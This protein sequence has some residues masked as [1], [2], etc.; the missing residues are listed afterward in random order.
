MQLKVLSLFSGIGAFEK[1]LSN[2]GV[3]FDLV[4][5]CEID[6]EASKSYSLIHGVPE[7]LN[8]RDITSVTEKTLPKDL[9]LLTYGFP[10]QDLSSAGKMRGLFNEDGTKTRSGLFFDALRIIEEARPKVAIAENVKNLA[11]AKFSEAFTLILSELKRVGYNNYWA[12]VKANEQGLP[13]TR[14]R[15]IIVS[16]REDIDTK[17]FK[18]PAPCGL[19]AT[20]EELADFREVD[21]LTAPFLAYYRATKDPHA[22]EEEFLDYI[23]DL[24]IRKNAIHSKDLQMYS[25]NEMNTITLLSGV[26]GTLTCRNVVNYN[27]KFLYKGRLFRPSPRMCFRLMGFSDLDFDKA[28]KEMRDAAL[29]KQA[30]NS[31]PVY[32]LER[33]LAAIFEAQDLSLLAA[34]EG[35]EDDDWML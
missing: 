27:K 23:Q 29:Y 12:V 21:D 1:A 2:L 18:F 30:G 19:R 5:Y 6:P 13:Q 11:S 4:N 20:L 15:V 33:I 16:I 25:F 10:C 17:R 32:M 22:T 8:L 35:V 34:N 31:I 24:P 28:Q 9:G 14:E 7:A 26:C 3:P